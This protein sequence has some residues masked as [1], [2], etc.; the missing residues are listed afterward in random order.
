MEEEKLTSNKEG[1]LKPIVKRRS[2][3]FYLIEPLSTFT[4]Q[5]K[6]SYIVDKNGTIRKASK[7]NIKNA[8]KQ[9]R[10]DLEIFAETL[11]IG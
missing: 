6:K 2:G 3:L 9:A 7:Q 4:T 10:E 1:K 11:K 8:K 5:D